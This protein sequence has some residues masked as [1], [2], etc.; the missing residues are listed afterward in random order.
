MKQVLALRR[1]A[2][3]E[4]TRTTPPDSIDLA[5]GE[6]IRPG[7]V[8][9]FRAADD[10]RPG[11]PEGLDYSRP[12]SPEGLDY[13]SRPGSP[14][15]LHYEGGDSSMLRGVGACGGTATARA[16]VLLDVTESRRLDAGAVLVTKQTDPGSAGC[17][18]SSPAW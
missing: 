8:Q 4:I 9:P 16:A 17:P 13:N 18:R 3:A 1:R 10:S 2:H 6:Y 11:S 15:G 12:G 14:Q 5:P 7:V